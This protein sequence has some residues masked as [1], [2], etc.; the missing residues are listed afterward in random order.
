MSTDWTMVAAMRQFNDQADDPQDDGGR[1]NSIVPSHI[2]LLSL[3]VM[4]MGQGLA[5]WSCDLSDA[6]SEKYKLND[7]ARRCRASP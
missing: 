1:K 6:P 3:I 7:R 5:G 2:F 4:C